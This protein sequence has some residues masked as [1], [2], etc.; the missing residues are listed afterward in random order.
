MAFIVQVIPPIAF[1]IP[2]WWCIL[3]PPF[4]YS[5]NKPRKNGHASNEPPRGARNK[6]T[7]K[8]LGR[9]RWRG[10]SSSGIVQ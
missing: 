5:A 2:L 1:S 9:R 3:I 7:P 6:M 10:K 8:R 4:H